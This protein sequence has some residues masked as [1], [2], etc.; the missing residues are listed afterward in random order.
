M[1][2]NAILGSIVAE[3][4]EN[5]KKVSTEEI[6]KFAD[7]VI[8]AKR[9]FVAGA[10]RSGFAARA[11]SNRTMHLGKIVYF[12][13]EPTTPSIGEGDV[14]VIGSGSG[15]TGSLV[16]MANKAKKLGAKIAT[17][18]IHPEASIGSIADAIITIPGATPKSNLA[19]TVK[20][21][22]PMGNAFEQMS[23][24][25]YDTAIMIMMDKLG[26]NEKEMFALHANLE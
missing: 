20:S 16:G 4:A 17:L 8:S 24:L 26:K 1:D 21:A 6:E 7:L 14:L 13:G 18:T 23:W 5:A 11:F 2:Y 3:L 22:Q 9:V 15:E 10:G 25:V 19:D 12:V